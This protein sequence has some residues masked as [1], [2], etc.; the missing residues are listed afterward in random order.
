MFRTVRYWGPL[1]AGFLCLIVAQNVGAIAGYVLWIA[2]FAL[3]LDGA[4]ATWAR[5][6]R[7]GSLT[8]HRQ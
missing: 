4:T 7:A 5:N 3:I 6:G 1:V 2:A 8:T